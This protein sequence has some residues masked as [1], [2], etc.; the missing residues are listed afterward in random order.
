M[1]LVWLPYMQMMAELCWQLV[2]NRTKKSTEKNAD[3]TAAAITGLLLAV[4]VGLSVRHMKWLAC[5]CQ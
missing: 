1:Q 3:T 4:I 5:K 2:N